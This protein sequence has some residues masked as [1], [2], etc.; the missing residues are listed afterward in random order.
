MRGLE[1][2]CVAD[3]G[4]FFREKKKSRQ[5]AR[6]GKERRRRLRVFQT[7]AGL[8]KNNRRLLR[9]LAWKCYVWETHWRI[10]FKPWTVNH[11]N[12]DLVNLVA[13]DAT[14]FKKNDG[15]L[16]H[17]RRMIFGHTLP[18]VGMYSNVTSQSVKG[19]GTNLAGEFEQHPTFPPIWADVWPA[20][21]L[22]KIS[23]SQSCSHSEPYHC[24]LAGRRYPQEG[25]SAQN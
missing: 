23:L 3:A 20:V 9:R 10:M 16:Q 6:R 19:R 11:L 12:C 13:G 21:R 24:R 15:L 17:S 4:L 18:E 7:R 5:R 2:A 8:W 25:C 14:K 1:L 22:M